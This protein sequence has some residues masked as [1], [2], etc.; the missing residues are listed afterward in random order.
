[1]PR[2]AV[3]WFGRQDGTDQIVPQS[4]DASRIEKACDQA[5]LLVAG[6]LAFP[7]HADRTCRFH[8]W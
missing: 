3:A 5:L 8:S 1:M 2:A 4:D 6:P 7:I